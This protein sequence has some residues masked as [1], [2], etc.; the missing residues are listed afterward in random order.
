MTKI[1]NACQSFR[2]TAK[3]FKRLGI[4]VSLMYFSEK[5]I[6]IWVG[7]SDFREGQEENLGVKEKYLIF[8]GHLKGI[9]PNSPQMAERSL[10]LFGLG[11]LPT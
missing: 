4:I 5:I 2:I 6:S 8:S 9:R 10:T 1:S 3:A 11:F 7:F